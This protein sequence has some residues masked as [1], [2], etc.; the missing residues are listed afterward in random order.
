MQFLLPLPVF[1]DF[2][3]SALRELFSSRIFRR[4]IIIV[5]LTVLTGPEHF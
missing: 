2:L 3:R 4:Q 1:T 5:P